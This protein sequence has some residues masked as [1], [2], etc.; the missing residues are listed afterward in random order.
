MEGEDSRYQSWH[1]ALRSKLLDFGFDV[2]VIIGLFGGWYMVS[3][4]SRGTE[5][6]CVALLE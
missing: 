1:E 5:S 6:H 2:G 4:N 3:D